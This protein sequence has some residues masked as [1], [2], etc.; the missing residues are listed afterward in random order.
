MENKDIIYG[1]NAV[2]GLFLSEKTDRINKIIITEHAKKDPKIKNILK[3]AS[4]NRIPVQIAPKE[5]LSSMTEQSH[6]G[7]IAVVAPISYTDFDDFAALLKGREKSL[8]ILLDGV[9]DPHNLGAIIRS[10]KCAGAQGVIIPKR[11]TSLVTSVVEKCSAGAVSQLPIVQVSNLNN[12]IDDLKKIGFWVYGAEASGSENYFDVR[13][14]T[15]TAFI[16]GGENQGISRLS[17]KKCDVLIKIPMPGEFNSL[18]VS[19][20]AAILMFEFVRQQI[21]VKKR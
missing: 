13:Y 9:E 11:R 1:K 10:A 12:A 20:A 2:E 5:K 16:L 4:D 15:N 8:V 19:N 7:I 14:D 18:N 17:A 3:L 21:N 6:Q